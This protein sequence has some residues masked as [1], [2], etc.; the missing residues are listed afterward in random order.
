PPATPHKLDSTNRFG[1]F[2]G[3]NPVE[4]NLLPISN[5]TGVGDVVDPA[6]LLAEPGTVRVGAGAPAGFEEL[7]STAIGS[8]NASSVTKDSDDTDAMGGTEA[9]TFTFNH[10]ST[11][12]INSGPIS[13]MS[14]GKPV[15]V[16]FDLA[17]PDDGN[18][19]DQL[20]VYVQDTSSSFHWRRTVVMPTV[21]QGWVNYAFSF[22]PRTAG[23]STRLYFSNADSGELKSATIGRARVY[24]GS[25]RQI[26]GSRP[27]VTGTSSLVTAL[28]GSGIVAGTAPP[29]PVSDPTNFASI[30]AGSYED[31]TITVT[32][33][34][35]GDCVA[36]G[37]PNASM[38]P[39]V[40]YSAWVSAA[41]TV[42]VRAEN[43]TGGSLNPTGGSF[44]VAIVR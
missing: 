33:A 8:F 25:E 22:V 16:E 6:G 44:N 1:P 28:K 43:T 13:A 20:F 42:T 18:E 41:D 40:I 35:E 32:G 29:A 37:V 36:L 24:H 34:V 4:G 27:A 31:L 21:A 10:A 7:T 14:P 26:G 9:A 17:N 39:G 19:L 12:Q 30:P 15:W 38:T 3:W 23:T 2:T 5:G 11:A